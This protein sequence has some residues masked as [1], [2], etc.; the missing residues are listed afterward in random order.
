MGDGTVWELRA[1][2]ER[3]EKLGRL[4]RLVMAELP[5]RAGGSATG[6][7][8]L[9]MVDGSAMGCESVRAGRALLGT[10]DGP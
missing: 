2:K 1:R 4:V 6:P 9:E 7:G 5:L 3:R 8:V 10:L